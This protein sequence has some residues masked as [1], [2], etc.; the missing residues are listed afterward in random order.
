M[1]IVPFSYLQLNGQLSS[2]MLM[3]M[4]MV[5]LGPKNLVKTLRATR[6]KWHKW[7]VG[8]IDMYIY[9]YVCSMLCA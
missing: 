5:I 2:V 6:R 7:W 1:V 3:D 9:M 4:K 8:P